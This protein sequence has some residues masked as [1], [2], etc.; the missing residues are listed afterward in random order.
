MK[1]LRRVRL[2]AVSAC[3]CVPWAAPS[4]A[5]AQQ[6]A[7]RLQP[8]AQAPPQQQPP[9]Q[10][11]PQQTAPPQQQSP[12]ESVPQLPAAPTRPAQPQAQ[13]PAQPQAAPPQSTPPAAGQ[14]QLE[15]PK[16]PPE[17][18]LPPAAGQYV[19]AVEFR[20]NRRVPQ[21]MLKA[22]I[23]TK[24][25]DLYSEEALRRDF[26][27]LWNTNRFDDLR[28]EAEQGASGLILR[29]VVTERRTI[30]S[31][32][33]VGIHSV[34]VSEILDRFKDH[35][36]GLATDSPYDPAKIARA[37]VELKDFLGERGH[38][39]AEV[40]P[41]LE[42]IPP[43]TLTLKFV[44]DEGPKVKVG[45]IIFQGNKSFSGRFIV[46]QMKN[47]KPIGIP[48]SI[49]FENIFAK[50]YDLTKLED[51]EEHI[52]QAY[53]NHGFFQAKSL[54]ETVKV[55]RRG[56]QGWRL[57]VVHMNLPGIYADITI[58]IEEGRQYR[59]HNVTFQ[60]VKLFRTPESLMVPLFKMGRGD[61]FSAEKLRKGLEAMRNLYGMYGYIDFVPEP[62][63][64]FVPD[65]DNVDL[66]ITA[67]EG[68]QFF[69]RRIDF[70]GNVTT[71]DKVIRRE[72]LVDEGDV[73]AQNMWDASIL[74]LNQ[75]G[76]FE[77]LKKD[78]SLEGVH[79]NPNS[80]TVDITLKVKER[81]KNSIG[82]NGGVSGI[83]GTFIGANYSTNNFLGLGETLSI[84]A[85]LGTRM[86]NV[87]L[88]FTEPYL[89]DRPIQAGAMV[90]LRRFTF[91]QA[92]EAS[93]LSGQNLIPL[94]NSLG[95][96]NLLNYSQNSKG[97]TFS[98]ST[99]LRRSFAQVG[100]TYGY[101]ISNIVTLTTAAQTYFQYI[102]FSG[103]SGP[104]ALNGIKTSHISPSYAYNRVNHPTTPN[105]GHSI[106][107]SVDFAGSVLG[108]SVN[109]VRPTAEIKYFHVAPWHK[110][111][112]LALH[113]TGS[114]ITGYGGKF[115]PPFSRTFIGG[116]MDVRGFE[117]WGISPIA[118]IPSST[119]AQVFNDDGSARTQRVI[120]NG[121]SQQTPVTM[122]LPTYQLI[123]PGGD[124]HS[125][126]NFE[127]RMPVF[128]PVTMALFADAG[129]NKI[130]RPGELTMDASRVNDL[131]SQFPQA[132][133]DGKVRIVPGTQKM[134]A[135][136]GVEL[137]V[138]LPVVQAP[139][140]VYFAYN[141]STFRDYLQPPIV[142]DRS[143]FPNYATFANSVATFGQATPFFEK[144][145]MFRFT[146]GRTF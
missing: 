47:L 7:P 93:L 64:D 35:K 21:D 28:L 50:T 99:H 145:T 100:L 86:D 45:N 134:R 32:D 122:T 104:N 17:P 138:L 69:V 49:L 135:S 71:R 117:N 6:A 94:Y 74:R 65:T 38:E 123:T 60:G 128:G 27:Q 85:Q 120:V 55:V 115:V 98:T 107:F 116:E 95:S 54:D 33:Y 70:S 14:P 24:A 110:S 31:I 61:V 1:F 23:V 37:V 81:G 83:A 132:G 9:A 76:Y 131:N 8:V 62:N 73:F 18:Q 2:A 34:T 68:K 133:F 79:R 40:T 88:G 142:A 114:L 15:V 124:F 46:S 136:T 59:L 67:D 48:H 130:L 57:P 127:Y 113:L 141:P 75:L 126:G 84:E 139:F 78:E 30:R 22:M 25:G 3:L 12:F 106:F 11:A 13:P 43:A 111:H 80:N 63:F 92:R 102:N 19:E 4:V 36:V 26:M 121:V 101:D 16:A 44:V 137:Q 112:V 58:P 20:G 96:Q 56:G 42:Q 129:I 109:T 146:I 144:R 108:G 29:F 5:G 77:M 143:S 89:F 72:L 41:V 52:R 119:S 118:F 90:Y 125:V 82:L 140:R 66:T 97:F 10:P 39:Y 105:A 53:L 51:D 103:V 87:S 91:D